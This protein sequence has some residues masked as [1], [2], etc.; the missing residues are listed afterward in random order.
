MRGHEAGIES[1]RTAVRA[2]GEIGAGALTLYAFS[3]ENWQRPRKEVAALMMMLRRF[4]RDE[5]PEL[6]ENNVR[7]VASGRLDDLSPE[8]RDELARTMDATAG[9][10]PAS[11]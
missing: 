10:T 8:V 2:C 7:L 11:C 1:V 6:T 5:M 4:L 9:S 3:V